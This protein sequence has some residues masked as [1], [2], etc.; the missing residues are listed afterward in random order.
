MSQLEA[1]GL[2]HQLLGQ[3][4]IEADFGIVMIA[5][6]PW[7]VFQYRTDCIAV[8]EHSGVWV[9][10]YGGEWR[11]ISTSCTLIDAI[12]AIDILM[13]SASI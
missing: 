13:H 4:G 9:G 8:D 5:E 7:Q 11:C 12:D 1:K 2:I 6:Q 3:R 10:P